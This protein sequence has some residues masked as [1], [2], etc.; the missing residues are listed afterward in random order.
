VSL[1]LDELTGATAADASGNGW[2]GTLVNGPLWAGGRANGALWFDGAN[3]HATLP[4][5][6][7]NGLTVATIAFWADLDA[8]SN[9]TR[10][11]DFGTGTTTYM[12]L[13][14][15]NGAN[16]ALRFAITTSGGAGEQKIDGAATFPVTGWHHVAVT[17]AGATGTL[18][19]DGVQ[20]GQNTAMTLS[21]SSLGATTL[22]RL[23][24]SQYNDPY[25]AGR[26]DEFRVYSR[27]LSAAE[28]ASVMAG[29]PGGLAAPTGVTAS[30]AVGQITVNWT[31]VTGATGY[32][33]LRST[34]SGGPYVTVAT[35]VSGTSN[36]NAALPSATTY[37]YVVVARN[38][39]SESMNSAQ[40]SA[41]TP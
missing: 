36:T 38:A 27:A 5:G 6:V 26:V 35:N 25:L 39:T 33:V 32:E 37:Y 24:R 19:V 7:V 41:T 29:G 2:S 15:K 8:A 40:V 31:A 16:G 17:L 12:F 14:P 23:G 10:F 28:V 3:D 18:Y 4:T 13:T 9:W 21:P 11:F 34:T 30:A 20:V 1:K 22:N